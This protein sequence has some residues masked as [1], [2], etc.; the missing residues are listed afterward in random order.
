MGLF[1]SVF[2]NESI[3]LPHFPEEIDRSDMIWQSKQGLDV[4]SGPYRITKDHRLERKE[5]EY[6]EKTAEE[7]LEE[8][9]KWGFDSWVEYI[10]AYENHDGGGPPDEIEYDEENE[11]PPFLRPDKTTLDNEWWADHNMHGTFEFHE[12]I[13]RDPIEWEQLENPLNG[14]TI[15]RPSEYALDVYLQYEAH[16]HQGELT[17]F[18][19]MGDRWKDGV[20]GVEHALNQIEQWRDWTNQQ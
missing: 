3:D 16:F 6:R 20:D 13:R 7:K 18:T 15:E 5:R 4:Y 10:S 14:D 12:I 2:V 1:A 17:G 9:T 11:R 8:A 19:F